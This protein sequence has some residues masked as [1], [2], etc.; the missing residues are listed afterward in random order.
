MAQGLGT[1]MESADRVD[2]LSDARV[3]AARR[4]MFAVAG[5]FALPAL[6]AVGLVVWVLIEGR[7]GAA[8]SGDGGLGV[9]VVY[10][11][12]FLT[13]VPLAHAWAWLMLARKTRRDGGRNRSGLVVMGA[14]FLLLPCGGLALAV[15][16]GFRG[17]YP[18]VALYC[19][20]VLALGARALASLW[21]D[22][23]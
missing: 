20:L 22:S 2:G 9:V 15:R 10:V 5:L 16:T 11:A 3:A 18:L 17:G 4:W 8:S 1:R 19:V 12:L 14:A 6:Y 13:P 21:P 23:R 7:R